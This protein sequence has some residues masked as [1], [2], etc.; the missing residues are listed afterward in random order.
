MMKNKVSEPNNYK[1]IIAS[2]TYHCT[3]AEPFKILSDVGTAE[4][5]PKLQ[6]AIRDLIMLKNPII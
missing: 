3:N 1:E 4:L 2:G 6:I 5:G